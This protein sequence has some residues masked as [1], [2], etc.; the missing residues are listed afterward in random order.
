MIAEVLSL[1]TLS[2]AS[3]TFG[4]LLRQRNFSLSTADVSFTELKQ[5]EKPSEASVCIRC[6]VGE[7]AILF[8]V[9]L[10]EMQRW[11]EAQDY[12]FSIKDVPPALLE[13]MIEKILS[14]VQ[15]V[16]KE[17]FGDF[18]ALSSIELVTEFP[19][20]DNAFWCQF[21]ATIGAELAIRTQLSTTQ[22]RKLSGY[23]SFKPQ[24]ALNAF[25][26]KVTPCLGRTCLSQSDYQQLASGDV[27]FFDQCY[28]AKEQRI[29]L[30]IENQ[31]AWQAQL[32]NHTITIE[33]PWST[34]MSET[35]LA[36]QSDVFDLNTVQV[37]L[38]FTL[39][40]QTLPLPEVQ[41]LQPGYVFESDCNPDSPIVIKV[42]NQVV[43]N[44]ELVK[45]GEK[46]GVRILDVVGQ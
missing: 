9:S 1:K 35:Q 19:T 42:N 45:I 3:V 32:T 8:Y 10:D 17:L 31:A 7:Y 40:S 16:F 34:L 38:D 21:N 25:A 36:E 23:F 11:L 6:S 4:N 20:D 15:P 26:I 24:H 27:V 41:G 43:A 5:V 29:A 33:K 13:A 28:F 2:P 18:V 12:Q 46:L 37:E 22:L 44:G 30:K 39:P 14:P